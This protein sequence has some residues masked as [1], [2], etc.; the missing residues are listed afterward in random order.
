DLAVL[1]DPY[2]HTL[3]GLPDRAE[4]RVA[5]PVEAG[6]G[7]VLAH[8]VALEDLE[9]DGMEEAEDV[10]GDRRGA[11]DERVGLVE[12]GLLANLA[13]H[14]AVGQTVAQPLHASRRLAPPAPIDS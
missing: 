2:V 9:S 10:H 6:D 5:P 4:P 12:T 14:E 3:D 8:P 13:K 7:H 11:G 1:G